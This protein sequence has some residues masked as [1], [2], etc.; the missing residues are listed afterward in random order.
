M[1]DLALSGTVVSS[2]QS[3]DDVPR[4]FRRAFHRDHPRD[5]LADGRIQKALK[6]PGSET[7]RYD[8]LENRRGVGQKFVIVAHVALLTGACGSGACGSSAGT[9]IESG[10]RE[11]CLDNRDLFRTADEL[12]V[13]HVDAVDLARYETINQLV[14]NLGNRVKTRLVIE[15]RVSLFN[16]DTSI[17]KG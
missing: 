13:G 3:L 17:T 9:H 12:R 1:G 8:F 5:L 7:C 16:G 2:R 6:E 11:Q 10:K 4:I 14:G 15:L